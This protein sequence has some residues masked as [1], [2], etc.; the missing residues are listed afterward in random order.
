M[1]RSRVKEMNWPPREVCLTKGIQ[2][3]LLILAVLWALAT[4]L[5]NNGPNYMRIEHTI[6]C[7]VSFENPASEP[8]KLAELLRDKSVGTNRDKRGTS[9]HEE[10]GPDQIRLEITGIHVLRKNAPQKAGLCESG[11]NHRGTRL[12]AERFELVRGPFNSR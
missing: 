7:D 2:C 5:S 9:V 8:L 11:S 12:K 3:A 1:N 6:A 10:N 4:I